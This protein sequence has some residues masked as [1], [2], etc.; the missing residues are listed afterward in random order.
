[1]EKLMRWPLLITLHLHSTF[2]YNY[3]VA[4]P[5]LIICA[6]KYN[7]L[8]IKD[9]FKKYVK[10]KFFIE[11]FLKENHNSFI[12]RNKFHR[13]WQREITLC[14]RVLYIN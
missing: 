9:L 6:S 8:K 1:M 7:A 2:L 5:Y 14:A 13:I 10:R 11:K 3:I 4:Y 12:T